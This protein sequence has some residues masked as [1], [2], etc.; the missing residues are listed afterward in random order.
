M[1]IKVEREWAVVNDDARPTDRP[2]PLTKLATDLAA[3]G[4]LL[5]LTAVITWHHAIFDMWLGRT[6]TTQQLM[7]NYW[8]PGQH[9]RDFD[10]P[11]WNPHQLTGMPFAA[12]PLSGWMMFPVMALFAIL[13]P[14]PALKALL[15]FQVGFAALTTYAYARVLGMGILSGL[16]GANAFAFGGFLHKNA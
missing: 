4:V 13:G 14:L 6:D 10:I 7:P 11:G 3:V 5:A 8:F 15:A 2:S 16:V 9:L 12:D 1:V